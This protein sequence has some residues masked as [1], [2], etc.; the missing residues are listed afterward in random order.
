MIPKTILVIPGTQWQLGLIDK[1]KEMGHRVLVV[2][3]APNSPGFDHADGYLQCDIFDK[4]KVIA[5]GKL[6]DI[7]GV[8]TDQCDIAVSLVAELGKEFGVPSIDKKSAS[9]FTNKFLMREFCKSHGLRYP[10]YKY[11]KCPDDA[12]ALMKEIKRPIVIKPIDSNASHGVFKIETEDDLRKKFP[13]SMSF[14]RQDKCVIAERFID[15]VEFTVDGIKTPS[16]HFT[17]AISEKKHFRHNECVANELLFSHTNPYFDYDK[18]R[19][20]NDAFVMQTSLKFGFTHAEYKY[21]NGEFY[22]IEIAARGGGNMISSV[23]TQHMTGYD[24]YRYLIEC[25]TGNI[26]EQNF[27]IR[28][29]YKDKVAILKFFKTPDDGGRVKEVQGLEYLE[30]EPEIVQYKLN[31]QVG[32]TIQNASN[33]SVRIGFYIVCSE[34]MHNLCSVVKNVEEKFKIIY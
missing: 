30:S 8:M 14:S 11:C 22:L 31:F 13:E 12:I 3:P 1:I 28:P 27:S 21:E 32:D 7:N 6:N 2:N 29:E 5:Y 9:L 20:V 24:T 17:L 10:E 33:D 25:A 15:G 19:K 34:N 26:C 18:I 4:E 16:S 23:I